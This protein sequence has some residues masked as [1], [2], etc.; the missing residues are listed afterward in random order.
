[1]GVTPR[2]VTI[3]LNWQTSQDICFHSISFCLCHYTLLQMQCQVAEQRKT[4]TEMSLF[5]L[6]VKL[7]S[8]IW[9]KRW[10]Y[11]VKIFLGQPWAPH[12]NNI[13]FIRLLRPYSFLL[14]LKMHYE[15]LIKWASLFKAFKSLWQSYTIC[16]VS[17]IIIN[18]TRVLVDAQTA[19]KE[20][21]AQKKQL[22]AAQLWE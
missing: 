1:M 22:L 17:G 11:Y 13:C 21:Y 18:A 3:L 9:C 15:H 20:D 10:K 16:S 4:A 14:V 7:T 12:G 6:Y 8:W 5:F 19:S 2:I